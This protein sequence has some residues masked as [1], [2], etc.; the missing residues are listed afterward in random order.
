LLFALVAWR[1]IIPEFFLLEFSSDQ[2]IFFL[3]RDLVFVSSLI[4]LFFLDARHGILPDLITIPTTLVLFMLNLFL[5]VS[6]SS[7]LIGMITLG[8]FFAIQYMISRGAWVGSGDIRFG[9]LLGAM[10]GWRLGLLS[11]ALAYIFGSLFAILLLVQHKATRKSILPFGP[12]LSL[13]GLAI[14]FFGSIFLTGFF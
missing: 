12:F 8:G 5:G 4:V 11:L 3:L 13:S 7:L 1:Y 6:W 10:F 2:L 14:L 9:L